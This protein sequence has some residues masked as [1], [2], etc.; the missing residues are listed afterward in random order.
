[1]LACSFLAVL[2]VIDVV[3][4]QAVRI[5]RLPEDVVDIQSPQTLAAQIRYLDQFEGKRV[6]LLGDSVVYGGSLHEHGDLR[7]RDHNLSALIRRDFETQYPGQRVC[8]MNLGINGALPADL[9]QVAR[10]LRHCKIDLWLFDVGLRSFSA[11]FANPDTMLSRSWL[12]RTDIDSDGRLFVRS[13]DRPSDVV[14]D[15]LSDSAWNTW[16]LYR[17]RDFLQARYFGGPPA[18]AVRTGRVA[19]TKRLRKNTPADGLDPEFILLIKARQRF[20]SIHLR[21]DNPQ[22]QA[23]ER[24]LDDLDQ[25]DQKVV[26]FYARE[27][28]EV[29]E[30]LIDLDRYAR[31]TTELRDVIEKHRSTNIA[32]LPGIETMPAERYLDHVHIDYQGYQILMEH[33][34]PKIRQ[35][36][37][38]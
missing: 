11:D 19:A 32:Y 20:D 12:A 23:L 28:P 35:L 24:L 17:W 15:R 29:L 25:R 4:N 36:V 18:E 34:S 37:D 3:L 27:N 26:V 13:G 33:L 16:G 5:S 30:D 22:R 38:R 14:E 8:V 7:W 2:V 21:P 6:V 10:L 9:E 1:M 31:L